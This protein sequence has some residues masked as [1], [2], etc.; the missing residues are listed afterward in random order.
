MKNR[1]GFKSHHIFHMYCFHPRKIGK[2]KKLDNKS[3]FLQC[4]LYT[5]CFVNKVTLLLTYSWAGQL[6]SASVSIIVLT[7]QL[8]VSKTVNL[9]TEHP[10]CLIATPLKTY[11]EKWH[12]KSW[13]N[14]KAQAVEVSRCQRIFDLNYQL[15]PR[16]GRRM[17]N[18]S[19]R[20]P[21]P[22]EILVH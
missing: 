6:A 19:L 16:L 21:I 3:I 9:L 12:Q 5:G 7:A 20:R 4:S 15:L 22:N 8:Q 18:F 14:K 13:D 1:C 2:P 10:V 17:H 11:Q